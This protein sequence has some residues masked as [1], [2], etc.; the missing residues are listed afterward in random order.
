[1]TSENKQLALAACVESRTG[2][3]AWLDGNPRVFVA[4]VPVPDTLTCD[5]CR[6]ETRHRDVANRGGYKYTA[7]ELD[8]MTGWQDNRARWDDAKM[9]RWTS[10]DPL[11]F[12]AGDADLYRYVGN[13]PTNGVDPTGLVPASTVAPIRPVGD[14]SLRL[15]VG[16]VAFWVTD[17]LTDEFVKLDW[18][19]MNFTFMDILQQRRELKDS[20]LPIILRASNEILKQRGPAAGFPV[21][22]RAFLEFTSSQIIRKVTIQMHADNRQRLGSI[23]GLGRLASRLRSQIEQAIAD[24]DNDHWE[25]RERAS[26]ELVFLAPFAV[27]YLREP[28]AS[29]EQTTRQRKIL[30]EYLRALPWVPGH[31]TLVMFVAA[32]ELER[33]LE[34]LSPKERGDIYKNWAVYPPPMR[35]C[36]TLSTWAAEGIVRREVDN[37]QECCSQ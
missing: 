31:D 27:D 20:E 14:P 36:S 8:S 18:R 25:V 32:G 35:N 19:G 28:G 16:L 9:G 13:D 10:Q 5:G 17:R 34:S 29:V 15:R 12:D 24:L 21:A 23:P 26:A 37:F 1:M 6:N 30:E 7:R 4:P 22:T 2:R 11:G 3:V 33:I